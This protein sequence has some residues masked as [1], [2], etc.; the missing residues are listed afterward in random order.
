MLVIEILKRKQ[1]LDK[2]LKDLDHYIEAL[3]EVKI[4]DK[5]SMYNKIIDRKFKLLS[6]IRSHNNLL[7]RL[8]ESTTVTLGKNSV[9]VS[10]AIQLR[11][12]L[13]YQIKTLDFLITKGDYTVVDVLALID[14]RDAFFEEFVILD[15]AIA[16]SD[17]TFDWDSDKEVGEG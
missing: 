1:F 14:Q 12:T 8:N 7:D 15:C 3:S 4:A 2:K 16:N 5:A 13:D 9:T 17:S 6:K 11:D 10:E